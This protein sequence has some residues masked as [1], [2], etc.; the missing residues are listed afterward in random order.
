MKTVNSKKLVCLLLLMICNIINNNPVFAEQ[1][2]MDS[3]VPPYQPSDT[4]TANSLNMRFDEIERVVN[5]NDDLSSLSDLSCSSG[6]VAKWDGTAWVCSDDTDTTYTAGSGLSLTGTEFSIQPG[7][8]SVLASSAMLTSDNGNVTL[9][10][11]YNYIEPGTGT[12]TRARA[13]ATISLP[14]HVTVTSFECSLIDNHTNGRL[15]ADLN[16]APRSSTSIGELMGEVSTILGEASPDIQH[17]LDNSIAPGTEQVDNANFAYWIYFY[18][19]D[20][21]NFDT[22]D[23]SLLQFYQCRAEYQ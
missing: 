8:V 21:D 4:L 1:L 23:P 12:G 7:Y 5:A 17:V 19:E 3:V 16:R 11:F 18:I 10:R 6:Q 13:L 15:L 2:N 22:G 14:D 9:Y 20:G